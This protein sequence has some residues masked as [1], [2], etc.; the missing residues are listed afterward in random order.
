MSGPIQTGRDHH[1]QGSGIQGQT[2]DQRLPHLAQKRVQAETLAGVVPQAATGTEMTRWW[3]ETVHELAVLYEVDH[4]MQCADLSAGASLER[5]ESRWG[6]CHYRNDYP[7]K[8]DKNWLCH[9]VVHRGETAGGP[10]GNHRPRTSHT[11]LVWRTMQMFIS[12]SNI[13]VN[14]E[15][16]FACGQCVDRCI[17]DN[18][19]CRLAPCRAACPIELNCQG[20]VRLYGP[21]PGKGSG[22]GIEQGHALCRNPGPHLLAPLRGRPASAT[23]PPSPS[24]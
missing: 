24:I 9:V 21:G 19:A 14:R 5:K 22:R 12:D 3:S 16:C 13:Y 20:Y 4:I 18:C 7:E 1:G 15:L 6:N 2:F 23:K 10:A 11:A 8:D 17:M